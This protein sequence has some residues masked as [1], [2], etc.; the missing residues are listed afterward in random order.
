MVTLQILVLSF[1][2]RVQVVQP[3]SR[4]LLQPTL[5]F[6]LFPSGQQ[7]LRHRPHREA[8]RSSKRN[9]PFLQ[10][11]PIA[12]SSPSIPDKKKSLPHTFVQQGYIKILQRPRSQSPKSSASSRDTSGSTIS[13]RWSST[14]PSSSQAFNMRDTLAR[15]LSSNIPKS[16]I[17]IWYFFTPL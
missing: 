13:L 1:L 12:P 9:H 14:I 10:D 11:L 3:K 6:A 15:V 7:A 16:V 2:V 17:L 5:F 8:F 4:L